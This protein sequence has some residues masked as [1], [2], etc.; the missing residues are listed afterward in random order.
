MARHPP[1]GGSGDRSTPRKKKR[2]AGNDE[3]P[4]QKSRRSIWNPFASSEP[5]YDPERDVGSPT[6]SPPPPTAEER[7]EQQR[8]TATFVD[9]A[10]AVADIKRIVQTAEATNDP[11]NPDIEETDQAWI[12]KRAEVLGIFQDENPRV[13]DALRNLGIKA[14]S[15]EELQLLPPKTQDLA[16]ELQKE[17]T[18][19][20]K[21]ALG[22]EGRF[23]NT[24]D[25]LVT[26]LAMLYFGLPIEP[27]T[28]VNVVNCN[29]DEGDD[30]EDDEVEFPRVQRILWSEKPL[31]F[32]DCY[33]ERSYGF[34]ML[35][36]PKPKTQNT[37]QPTEPTPRQLEQISIQHGSAGLHHYAP[38]PI[39]PTGSSL[40]LRGGGGDSN[41]R[42]LYSRYG[43]SIK[44]KAV[45]DKVPADE[46]RKAA[47]KALDLH[48][49]SEWTIVV[50]QFE[51]SE[52][53]KKTPI[54]PFVRSFIVTKNDFAKTYE[55]YLKD[56]VSDENWALSVDYYHLRMN[57]ERFTSPFSI[58]ARGPRNTDVL[59]LATLPKERPSRH[60]DAT[61]LPSAVPAQFEPTQ[62]EKTGKTT[63]NVFA[64]PSGLSQSFEDNAKSFTDSIKLLLPGG[65][66]TRTVSLYS[67]QLDNASTGSAASFDHS[68]LFPLTAN[69]RQYMAIQKRV[70]QQ[71][72]WTVVVHETIIQPP[73]H[74]PPGNKP[75]STSQAMSSP[76]A[77][78][79]REIATIYRNKEGR[80]IKPS[81]Q[82]F[83]N[84]ALRLLGIDPHSD[85]E[86]A[87]D[88]YS[89]QLNRVDGASRALDFS[90]TV[91]IT[92]AALEKKFEEEIRPRLFRGEA[93]WNIVVR[94]S[95]ENPVSSFAAFN[96]LPFKPSPTF[97]SPDMRP[98]FR[99]TL[100]QGIQ[101][102]EPK[103][104]TYSATTSSTVSNGPAYIYGY[105]GKIKV[106]KN[107]ESFQAGARVL[108]GLQRGGKGW[109]FTVD[110]HHTSPPTVIEVSWA[111]YFKQFESQIKNIPGNPEY[112]W[113]VFVRKCNK[114]ST[115]DLT[116]PQ[117]VSNYVVL[118]GK[119]RESYW[120]LPNP[121]D[122]RYG[123][124]QIQDGFLSAML[125]HYPLGVPRPA[126]DARLLNAHLGF[127]GVEVTEEFYNAVNKQIDNY[128]AD[129][130]AVCE[131]LPP[132]GSAGAEEVGIRLAGTE[133]YSTFQRGDFAGL[134]RAIRELSRAVLLDHDDPDKLA[135]SLPDQ[136]R[137]WISAEDREVDAESRLFDYAHSSD[138]AGALESWIESEDITDSASCIWFRP[139]W[140][141]F[142][143]T[144]QITTDPANM[145]LDDNQSEVIFHWDATNDATLQSFRT[146]F[147][148]LAD[149]G[150][151]T[152]TENFEIIV[153]K[154][155]QRFVVNSS[156]TEDEWRKHIFDYFHNKELAV[157][158]NDGIQCRCDSSDPWGI[159]DMPPT[160]WPVH[161]LPK[162]GRKALKHASSHVRFTHDHHG[163]ENHNSES[164]DG[165]PPVAQPPYEARRIPGAKPPIFRTSEVPKFDAWML[166]HTAQNQLQQRSW[167]QDQSVIEP[168]FAPAAPLY[169]DNL[170]LAIT[171]GPSMPTVFTQHLTP[172]DILQ[173]RKE[174]RKLLNH[175]LEREIGCP[176]CS[177]TFKAYDND[178]K[179]AHYKSHMDVLNSV[180]KC[181]M[182][183]E[184][185]A[186]FTIAQKKQHLLADFAKRESEDI[187][188]FWDDTRCP[189]CNLDLKGS[190]A[191]DIATHIA[192][193]VPGALK[194]CD[195][196]GFDVLACTPAEKAHHNRV[197]TRKTPVRAHGA[198]DPIHCQSCGRERTA[199]SEKRKEHKSCGNGYFCIRCGLNL[200]LLGPQEQQA[201]FRRCRVPNGGLGKYCKRCGKNLASLSAAGLASHNNECY[202]REPISADET[203]GLSQ[204]VED[205]RIKNAADRAD[206]LHRQNEVRVK[207]QAVLARERQ[208]LRREQQ[209]QQGQKKTGSSPMD[210]YY[211]LAGEAKCHLCRT[212]FD[213]YGRQD[214]VDHFKDMHGNSHEDS[215]ASHGLAAG[216]GL[217]PGGHAEGHGWGMCPLPGCGRSF[218][219][220][221]SPE[222]I[223]AHLR[224][225]AKDLVDN[226]RITDMQD[227]GLCPIPG[228]GFR[229]GTQ[230]R[231][232]I[233]DH[234]QTHAGLVPPNGAVRNNSTAMVSSGP[235]CHSVALNA[236]LSEFKRRLPDFREAHATLQRLADTAANAGTQFQ[237]A[238]MQTQTRPRKTREGREAEEQEWA[239]IFK[240]SNLLGVK[241]AKEKHTSKSADEHIRTLRGDTITLRA[242]LAALEEEYPVLDSDESQIPDDIAEA[243]AKVEE[244]D[245]KL[246]D[247]EKK[248]EKRRSEGTVILGRAAAELDARKKAFASS[249]GVDSEGGS[250][251]GNNTFASS[252]SSA[253]PSAPLTGSTSTNDANQAG[254]A[255][256]P[257]QPSFKQLPPTHVPRRMRSVKSRAPTTGSKRK[258]AVMDDCED[259]MSAVGDGGF[260]NVGRSSSKRE[261]KKMR[262]GTGSG[263]QGILADQEREGDGGEGDAEEGGLSS[264]AAP[265][266][267]GEPRKMAQE[268]PEDDGFE[269]VEEQDEEDEDMPV[270]GTLKRGRK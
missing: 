150:D 89:N 86:F 213:G 117:S 267:V 87:V 157:I 49:N 116:P 23:P 13:L 118:R 186:L 80:E 178:A 166:N 209:Q 3:G 29:K 104:D 217:S 146:A 257:P 240:A 247:A 235:A 165:P 269:D 223:G 32:L 225:H 214:I 153:A 9:A 50:D 36:R 88:L 92:K 199:A 53:Y 184:N 20:Y 76:Q 21:Q 22:A 221:T 91:R 66:R 171:V 241:Q 115:R 161:G 174:N 44:L 236:A 16:L 232:A 60:Q 94:P 196:C 180:G 126:E 132:P 193:H 121:R 191:E 71:V 179:V 205:Q 107:A 263:R 234:F 251:S 128:N 249:G 224:W 81:S 211:D 2:S 242:E 129:G 142:T 24:R 90:H 162:A 52:R 152:F 84:R 27:M 248:E 113:P 259:T 195:R 120:K 99:P 265:R 253:I 4:T 243:R 159:Y 28:Y 34:P 7:A 158:R 125:V 26:K 215:D 254:F 250:G 144:E 83:G 220:T 82:S 18:V 35:R 55:S 237:R 168:G 43:A 175:V 51:N 111:T 95:N 230:S 137:V 266:R 143:V 114:I 78:K 167:T 45:D 40:H 172:T 109:S 149:D 8:R 64:Y 194:F 169:G 246:E 140:K 185:W 38:V 138:I 141:H 151:D 112:S 163:N 201:H 79:T 164:T 135:L 33:H 131:N 1:P 245:Q 216:A 105:G 260:A 63:G 69:L 85:W 182:C 202:R 77:R 238:E 192:S 198:P 270:R 133:R 147:A 119:D 204:A 170:E 145:D 176:I 57:G 210:Q 227:M 122:G 17:N 156:T 39:Q 108:L 187:K 61:H 68:I 42:Y 110:L 183:E 148:S 134:A 160:S 197:C 58:P 54:K 14:N 97:P 41:Y 222:T 212:T 93:D 100:G 98:P 231:M 155:N 15:F 200:A 47:L 72:G 189:I 11:F 219:R 37:F 208:L 206:I 261:A 262:M 31:E 188:H 154:R 218:D 70:F 101:G 136:F 190:T 252:S 181:P 6:P 12:E 177:E 256:S 19:L 106:E 233:R 255:P 207:E 130:I 59:N 48:P 74:W 203:H 173:L 264:A 75:R 102:S 244:A 5:V 268:E 67:N 239:A 127:G 62:I 124:N 73:S 103:S 229:L 10:S 228:C 226:G 123:M 30:P 96:V 139:E 258:T 65:A 46:F 56:R 25:N